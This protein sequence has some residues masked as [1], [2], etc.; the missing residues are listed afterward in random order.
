MWSCLQAHARSSDLR[1]GVF[2]EVS[3]N[4][5]LSDLQKSPTDALPRTLSES[6]FTAPTQQYLDTRVSCTPVSQTQAFEVASLPSTAAS[7]SP[8]ATLDLDGALV[9]VEDA[10]AC[11]DGV[12]QGPDGEHVASLPNDGGLVASQP[13]QPAQSTQPF[14]LPEEECAPTQEFQ[15]S[16]SVLTSTA[17]TAHRTAEEED[18]QPPPTDPTVVPDEA[19]TGLT[20]EGA[21]CGA[22]AEGAES[23]G[24]PVAP[25]AASQGRSSR[26]PREQAMCA[27]EPEQVTCS[28]EPS[29]CVS[30]TGHE[31]EP[32]RCPSPTEPEVVKRLAEGKGKRGRKCLPAESMPASTGEAVDEEAP[33]QRRRR[34]QRVSSSSDDEAM[35]AGEMSLGP[36]PPSPLSLPPTPPTHLRARVVLL[37]YTARVSRAPLEQALQIWA[38]VGCTCRCSARASPRTTRTNAHSLARARTHTHTH[39]HKHKH[40][41]PRASPGGG[42]A[43]RSDGLEGACQGLGSNPASA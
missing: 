26:V 11:S 2:P 8:S 13:T 30:P 38:A 12:G 15:E 18:V 9:E 21:A 14:S 10:H 20:V 40:S 39:T 1:A 28:S 19:T 22:I 5:E 41:S 35:S 6:L 3:K 42:S 43:G 24:P 25:C 7:N 36:P 31:P 23:A 27:G 29:S 33:A 17:P 37:R 32:S 16:E 34:V 4:L